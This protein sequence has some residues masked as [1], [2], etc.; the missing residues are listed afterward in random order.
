MGFKKKLF[1]IILYCFVIKIK[2]QKSFI[3]K[4][5][6]QILQNTFYIEKYNI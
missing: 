3:S 4:V 6:K 2:S 5:R 1:F